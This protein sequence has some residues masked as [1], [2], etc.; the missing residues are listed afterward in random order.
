MV[1]KLLG[2]TVILNFILNMNIFLKKLMRK[3]HGHISVL[4]KIFLY[5][6]TSNEITS[7][8][9]KFKHSTCKKRGWTMLSQR[10]SL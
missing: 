3:H 10:A 8:E 7:K 4:G 6:R 2:H 1:R 5:T 9:M